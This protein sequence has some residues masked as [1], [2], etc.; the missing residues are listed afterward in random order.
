MDLDYAVGP[1]GHQIVFTCY[2]GTDQAEGSRLIAWLE[3]QGYREFSP[4]TV[5]M[6]WPNGREYQV[7]RDSD[8]AP[9]FIRLFGLN[10]TDAILIKLTFGGV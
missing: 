7:I 4:P 10:A 8:D 5:N 2:R 3:V 1:D 6:T 9:V